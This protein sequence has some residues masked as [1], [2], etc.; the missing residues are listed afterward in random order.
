MKFKSKLQIFLLILLLTIIPVNCFAYSNYVIPGGETIGI[1]VN[2]KGVLVVGFY[3][4]N[5]RYIGRDAGFEVGDIIVEVNDTLVHNIEEMVSLINKTTL[6]IK[7]KVE[8]DNTQ[9]D[10]NLEFVDDS[11]VLKT[12]LYVKD[13]I[14][15]IGTLTYIDPESKVFGALG[16]EIIENATISKFEIKDGIIYEANVSKIIK[17]QNGKAGE[18]NAVYDKTKIWGIINSNEVPGIFGTYSKDLDDSATI[19]VADANEIKTGKAAIRTVVMG[20]TVEEFAINIL[21]I[22]TS[23]K[24][25]NILFE[26][27]DQDL[28]EKTGGIVQGM[29]GSPI[30]QNNKL[31]GAVNYVIVNDTTKGYGIFITTMLEEGDK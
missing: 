10:I 13:K 14:N 17:S 4:V 7:F 12:G 5:D 22:D 19:E 8:R 16:H 18:K 2:S 23:S 28:I 11:N 24:S 30:I 31:I 20:N 1:E 25:K 3:K 6:P 15:G 9:L 27:V 21:H 26:V 29:S